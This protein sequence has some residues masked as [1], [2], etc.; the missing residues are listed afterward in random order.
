MTETFNVGDLVEAEKKEIASST[1]FRG[2]IENINPDGEP[3]FLVV[4]A[5]KYQPELA[6]LEREGF[7][8]TVIEKALP[9]L[10]TEPGI[11]AETNHPVNRV[12]LWQLSDGG[13]W[14]SLADAKYDHR[15]AEFAPFTRLAPVAEVLGKVAKAESRHAYGA[16]HEIA[17][18]FGVEL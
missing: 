15:A 6:W 12:N 3:P 8:V 11:Y 7:T 14:Y 13:N 4:S 16:A 17:A 9:P 5:Q 10:P 2:L 1:R 18:Q